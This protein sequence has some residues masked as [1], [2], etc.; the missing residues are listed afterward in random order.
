MNPAS[1]RPPGRSTR[2][3]SSHHWLKVRAEH[4]WPPGG[5]TTSESWAVGEGAEIPP[6]RRARVLQHESLPRPRPPGRGR[7]GAASCRTRSPARPPAAASTGP[8]LAAPREARHSN[9]HAP[10]GRPGNQLR[11]QPAFVAD[12]HHGTSRLPGPRAITTRARPGRVHFRCPDSTS[13]SPGGPVVAP[14]DQKS[15]AIRAA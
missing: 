9:R 15:S 1:S 6:C 8:L 13:R 14:R 5:N 10:P 3:A 11:G 4:R 2:N 7:A 12:E